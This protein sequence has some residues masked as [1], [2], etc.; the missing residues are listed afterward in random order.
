MMEAPERG[1]GLRW[2]GISDV[3]R[4][5]KN[6]EDAFLALVFDDKETRY[7]GKFGSSGLDRGDFVFAV[8]DGMGGAKS[9]EFASKIAVEKITRLLPKSL[10]MQAAKMDSGAIDILAELFDQIHQAV[11]DLGKY[12]EECRGMG[13][14]LSLCWLTQE[15]M[16]FGHIGDSRIYFL[17]KGG[18]M[19]QITEDHT[20]VG[21]LF[22]QG[23]INEREARSH[24]LRNTLMQVIGGGQKRI[25]PQFGR[26][27]YSP[28]DRIL[29][30][31][32]GLTDGLRDH[33][34]Q[35]FCRSD[36]QNGEL[37]IAELVR[38][39]VAESG[40]DNT[41]ALLVEILDSGEENQT[42]LPR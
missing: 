1:I 22:R 41:T 14:T 7:L 26:L 33:K 12:Y 29:L 18:E 37:R 15:W 10:G 5:R 36:H 35:D 8:S 28:G 34:I 19:K 42:F 32:D 40:R 31:S 23:L 27:H 24:P 38:E 2:S 25:E 3:G 21:M 20:R 13:A 30:C 4:F 6:N 9:G 16:Y 11:L 17:P 39:S